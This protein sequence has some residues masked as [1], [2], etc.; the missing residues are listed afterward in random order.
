MRAES[1]TVFQEVRNVKLVPV[2]VKILQRVAEVSLR[3]V[4]REILVEES[5]TSI[6][7]REVPRLVKTYTVILVPTPINTPGTIFQSITTAISKELPYY[8]EL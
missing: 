1:R 7:I 6:E 2:E 5:F 3:A 4:T 8:T